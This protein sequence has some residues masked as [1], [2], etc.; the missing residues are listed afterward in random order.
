MR[1]YGRV[2]SAFWQSEETRKFTEDGRQMALYLLTSPHANLI[3]CFRLPDAYAADDLQWSSEMV[4]EGFAELHEKG[5]VSR[6]DGTKWVFIHKYLKWNG[7]ENGNVAI[8]A[9]RAFDQVPSI[10]L[11]ALLAAALLEFG[12]HLKEPFENHLRTLIES[13]A[14]PE[15]EPEPIL[16]Q[17]QSLNQNPTGSTFGSPAAQDAPAPKSRAKRE[18]KAPAPSAETWTAYA[19]AYRFRYGVDPVRNAAVNGQVAQLVARLGADESPLVAAWYVGHKN[20]FYVSAGHSVGM[21]LR[22]AEKLRTQWATNRATTQTEAMQADKT[23]ANFN[24]FAPLLA[25]AKTKEQGETYAEH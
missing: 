20:Q 19:N 2:Y 11:K 14:N 1:D 24:A 22:D 12:S 6:D 23:A 16:I 8:A 9:Q 21:L 10:P 18:P 7:F 3:G 13:F 15:P 17:N 25:E 5:F 4:R